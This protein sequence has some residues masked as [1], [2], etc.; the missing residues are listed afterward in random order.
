L[1]RYTDL[2]GL[3]V[4]RRALKK[5]TAA[6]LYERIAPGVFHRSGSAD[7]TAGSWSAI[8]AQQPAATLC[9]LSAASLHDLT[10]EIPRRFNIAIP[11]GAHPRI[12][13]AL[14]I[15]LEPCPHSTPG[16]PAHERHL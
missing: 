14:Q 9:L 5:A 4:S 6:G 2:C 3:G 11:R 12:L 1:I 13:S 8:A 16:P 15:L 10:D 7:D